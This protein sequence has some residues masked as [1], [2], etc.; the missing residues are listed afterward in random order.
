MSPRSTASASRQP[1]LAAQGSSSPAVA[2]FRPTVPGFSLSATP[3]PRP[4]DTLSR[5]PPRGGG[6]SRRQLLLVHQPPLAAG[7]SWSASRRSL[8]ASPG[9]PAT[10]GYSSGLEFSHV[11]QFGFDGLRFVVQSSLRLPPI[12]SLCPLPP[13]RCS[14]GVRAICCCDYF[15]MLRLT[16]YPP[17]KKRERRKEHHVVDVI[18]LCRHPALPADI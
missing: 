11:C 1:S 9:L 12:V 10:A 6:T 8:P 3:D 15:L 18:W 5:P 7:F 2:S 17:I 16:W 14:T 4:R 13:S